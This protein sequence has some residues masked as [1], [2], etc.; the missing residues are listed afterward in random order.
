MKK[1]LCIDMV[2]GNSNRIISPNI[3][4]NGKMTCLMVKEDWSPF[5]NCINMLEDLKRALCMDMGK[6]LLKMDIIAKFYMKEILHTTFYV[7]GSLLKKLSII[8]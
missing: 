5:L 6:C 8:L 1:M 2:L 3:L 4:G 7:S